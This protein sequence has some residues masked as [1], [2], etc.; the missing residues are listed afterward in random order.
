MT[1]TFSVYH[2]VFLA[3]PEHM[4]MNWINLNWSA[5]I[6]LRRRPAFEKK[7]AG[8]QQPQWSKPHLGSRGNG[9]D[10]VCPRGSHCSGEGL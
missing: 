8:I 4:L 5:H 7:S 2:L 6:F 1:K 3:S 9:E 10:A